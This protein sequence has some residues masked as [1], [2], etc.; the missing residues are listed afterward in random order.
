[1]TALQ[2]TFLGSYN[3]EFNGKRLTRFR[4][5]N[6]QGLLAYLAIESSQAHSRDSLSTLLWPDEPDSVARH[7]L[8]QSLYQLR[9]L[10]ANDA[11]DA[12]PFLRITRQTVQFNHAS[13]YALDVEGCLKSIQQRK[14]A[15]VETMYT[16]EFLAGFTCDS[17]PFE[18]WLRQQR[19]RLHRIA[20]RSLHTLT[21]ERL[22]SGR[23]AYSAAMASARQ[24]LTLEPWRESAHR[25]LMEVL[26]RMGDRAAALA[27]YDRCAEVLAEDLGVS[28]APETFALFEA[29]R[30]GKFGG[31]VALPPTPQPHNVP[32][33]TTPLIGRND[34]LTQLL[35]LLGDSAVPLVTLTGPGGMGKSRLLLEAAWR[36]LDAADHHFPDGIYYVPLAPISDSALLPRTIAKAIGLSWQ[37]TSDAIATLTDYLRGKRLLLLLDN[38]EQLLPQG[39]EALVTL[40]AEANTIQLCVTSRQRLK[41]QAERVLAL[42]GLSPAAAQQLF[43][44]AARR[45]LPDF[46]PDEANRDAIR[47]ICRLAEGM[48]L[49]LVLAA[50]WVDTLSPAEIVAEIEQDLD[51][52]ASE[53]ADLPPRQRSMRAAFAYTWLLLDEAERT[54]FAQLSVF[55]GGFTSRAA[56]SIT[57]VGLRTLAQLVR[58]SLIAF[59]TAKERYQIHELLRQFGAEYLAIGRQTSDVRP[60]IV[61]DAHAAYYL[62]AVADRLVDLSGVDQVG[63]LHDIALDYENVRAAWRWAS[64]RQNVALL[65]HGLDG[66]FYYHYFSGRELEGA[67]LFEQARI[68]LTVD[69]DGVELDLDEATDFLLARLQ[70]R[71]YELTHLFRT[72]LVPDID[73]LIATFRSRDDVAEEALALNQLAAAAIQRR[74]VG[75]AMQ[76]YQKQL[77]LWQQVG[78]TLQQG[79]CLS[80]MTRLGILSGQIDVGLAAAEQALDLQRRQGDRSGEAL[81]HVMLAIYHTLWTGDY[82]SAETYFLQAQRAADDVRAAGHLLTAVVVT[83]VYRGFLALVAG[84]LDAARTLADEGLR[85]AARKNTPFALAMAEGL[86]AL[87]AATVGDYPRAQHVATRALNRSTQPGSVEFAQL[88]LALA[89]CATGDLAQTL[90]MLKLQWMMIVQFQ[91]QP[92]R[93]LL[94]FHLPLVAALL[95]DAGQLERAAEIL[96]LAISQAS[97]PQGWWNS[98]ALLQTTQRHV[99]DALDSA[100]FEAA[101][102]A[103][104]QQAFATQSATILDILQ[105]L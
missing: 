38:F 57:H 6:T 27:Q 10:L 41:L 47:T 4:S 34:T 36:V 64:E 59:D 3:V 82:E 73:R 43:M 15:A 67:A 2:L 61:R 91:R 68:L 78:N 21:H 70:N 58:K 80:N 95:A 30:D 74:D 17:V 40:L 20:L 11:A 85:L 51:F 52:L 9:K 86:D 18:A 16:G 48:P 29:I 103:G 54:A 23:R 55:R 105:A 71:E 75:G 35:A 56:R 87:L 37:S 8:R 94:L 84:K 72:D 44:Q 45:S 14:L 60:D 93:T 65:A 13:D 32:R 25:Q 50:A 90:T 22:Q 96:G 89:S 83:R 12:E 88:A 24:Q 69:R 7:N 39:R 102:S 92:T 101:W 97:T 46:D 81:I 28:P 63:T 76:I 5:A 1:M 31:D 53:L 79:L 104:S 33:Q 100:E 26:A 98:M 49:A 99:R 66:L 19:E 62:T 42:E 77:A